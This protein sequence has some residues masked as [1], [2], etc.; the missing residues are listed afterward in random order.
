[1]WK[2]TVEQN[3]PSKYTEG[4][5][6]ERLEVMS[7]ELS[8]LTMLIERISHCEMDCETT[9]KLEKVRVE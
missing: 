5:L 3:R 7:N 9:F 1:M 6:P 2:L 8:E 4:T